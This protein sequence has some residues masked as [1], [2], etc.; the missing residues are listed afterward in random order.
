MKK[1]KN[2]R[3][4][5][6]VL[7]SA[8]KMRIEWV[9]EK[10]LR[11][12]LFASERG[13]N[14]WRLIWEIFI[15]HILTSRYDNK[16]RNVRIDD[17]ENSLKAE[18]QKIKSSWVIKKKFCVARL[19]NCYSRLSLLASLHLYR[20]KWDNWNVGHTQMSG[21]WFKFVD[22]LSDLLLDASDLR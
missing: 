3:G 1:H 20:E 6:I 16:D 14:L 10:K 13:M 5:K 2:S 7:T 9:R 12:L 19:H 22:S 17:E 21:N 18:K 4:D 15:A 11:N 8:H